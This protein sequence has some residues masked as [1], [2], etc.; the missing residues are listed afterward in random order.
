MNIDNNHTNEEQSKMYKLIESLEKNVQMILNKVN[1]LN[2]DMSYYQMNIQRIKTTN[3]DIMD[4]VD[5]IN[6]RVKNIQ[7]QMDMKSDSND[8]KTLHIKS[9]KMNDD[10]HKKIRI[11]LNDMN[12][13]NPFSLLNLIMNKNKD[14]INDE[15]KNKDDKIEEYFDPNVEYENLNVE[16]NNIEDL[17]KLGDL[18]PK[19]MNELKNEE[20]SEI[21]KDENNNENEK[22]VNDEDENNNENEKSVNDEDENNNENE[23]SVNDEDENNNEDENS[24]DESYNE[25]ENEDDENENENDDDNNDDKENSEI[26][27]KKIGVYELNGKNYPL[28]LEKLHKLQEPL[29]RL[30]NLV[31]MEKVKESVFNQLILIL[32]NIVFGGK[33]GMMHTVITGPPGVGKTELGRILTDIFAATG[34]TKGNR[35]KIARRSDLISRYT[36]HTAPDIE[37][38]VSNCDVLFIDEAYSLGS[39][40]SEEKDTFSVEA[41]NTLNQILSEK[42]DEL[43][44]IIAGYE[45]ELNKT[46]FSIN[47]G[48]KRRFET[49]H[50]IEG[51]T[52]LEL[53]K[54]FMKMLDEKTWKTDLT[55]E[56]LEKFFENNKEYFP[57]YA[58]DIE[59]LIKKCMESN[60]K[61]TLI[62]NI[63]EKRLI[64]IIDLEKGF[65]SFKNNKKYKINDKFSFSSI[66]C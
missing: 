3:S 35:I 42:K 56:K 46:I 12:D 51:Y 4:S 11:T 20:Y 44:C 29:K 31:G 14:K 38:L 57:H 50:H 47:P 28:D 52:P 33:H 41:I 18:Y 13:M 65:E 15:K 23:K 6:S 24:D 49:T 37:K 30:I 19:I 1:I 16:I 40:N 45:E 26:K 27:K 2:E 66:Y 9:K 10:E 8:E 48:L 55:I 22:S 39:G 62:K 32:Q 7:L 21:S 25:D 36:G 61:R 60:A 58:G 64:S 43:V 59:S 53:S 5:Q 17:Y 34:I 54:I 63:N